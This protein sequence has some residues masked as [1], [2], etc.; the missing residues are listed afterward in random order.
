MN[1]LSSLSKI[2]YA[3]II[4]ITI[5]MI[6]LVIEIA[7][8]GFDAMRVLNIANFFL[9]WYMFINIKKVQSNIHSMAIILEDAQKGVLLHRVENHENGELQKLNFSI[10]NVLDQFEVF[11]K[12]VLGSFNATSE[13]RYHRRVVETGLHG[14]YLESAKAINISI[15]AMQK[16][17]QN[18]SESSINYQINSVGGG[19][20]GFQIIQQDLSAAIDSLGEITNRSDQISLDSNKTQTEIAA[21]TKDVFQIVELIAQ[22]G[23]KVH[24]L[25]ER[26]QEISQVIGFIN[27]IADQTNL[28]ALNAAIEA[29]RAGE[30]GRG[31]AV[32]ADEVRKLAERTQK[33]TQE[34]SISVNTLKQEMGE[35]DDSSKVMSDLATHLDTTMN[36]FS[37]TLHSFTEET[38]LTTK[39]TQLMNG[40]LFTILAKMDHLIFKNNAYASI[41]SKKLVQNFSD[42]H[43]CRFG[44]WYEGKGKELMGTTPSYSAIVPYHKT[45]H[46]MVLKNITF[47]EN[48]KDE[49]SAN[50]DFIIQNFKEMEKASDAL[51][52]TIGSMLTEYREKLYK[53]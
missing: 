13:G 29:A 15:E 32:V 36:D 25:S 41:T 24:A 26:T 18:I 31:F 53:D 45:I 50:L 20:T 47:I 42:H 38:K 39:D 44:K 46:D 16:N 5:F 48:N 33:A 3:N 17:M 12:E 10:N 11:T 1:N 23:T 51:F 30:H 19:I 4:S 21:T 8:Y 2:Q 52:I 7:V 27:D 40:M 9:A 43:G 49:V 22:T 6:A 28:L 35:I 37:N 14:S 34:I